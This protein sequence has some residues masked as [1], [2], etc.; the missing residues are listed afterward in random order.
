MSLENFIKELVTLGLEGLEVYYP[1]KRHRKI[2][3]FHTI[4]AVKRIAE[5]FNLI[6]TGGSD[7]HG[8]CL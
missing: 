6:Q 3:K 4:A 7:T 1:Y 5:K 2:I 8:S